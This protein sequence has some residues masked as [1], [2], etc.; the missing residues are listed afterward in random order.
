MSAGSVVVGGGPA[1]AAAAITLRSRGRPVL[2]LERDR[3]TQHKI[4]GEFLGG[5]ALRNL[6]ALGIDGTA[7]GA[8]PI[9]RMR[10]VRD[11]RSAEAPLP[12]SGM[13]LSRRT[14]DMAL[15][16]QAEAAGV[17]VERG[18]RV[19]SSDARGVVTADGGEV[20]GAAV[21]LAT[22]KHEL[23]GS[24]RVLPREPEDLVGF[25]MHFRLGATATAELAGAVELIL[26]ADAYA[27]LQR[28]ED[29]RANL[30]LLADRARFQAAGSTWHGLL[31]NLTRES[32]WLRQ[33]L[34]GGTEL[35]DRPLSIHRVPYGYLYPGTP[36]DG[37]FRLG[38]Q[39]GVIPSFTGEGMAIALQS[40]RFAGE[41]IAAGG[42]AGGYHR[43]MR[44]RVAR[45]I[46]LAAGLYRIGRSPAGQRA[47]LLVARRCP[48]LLRVAAR[49]TRIVEY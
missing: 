24:P 7:L 42:E 33:R 1:G 21:L 39:F 47:L 48:A 44:Q 22:G 4:C 17:A 46:A 11:A 40:G 13:G 35:F 36:E 45:P 19:R 25:K 9:A 10:V 41:W 34:D 14:L 6:A 12:F 3:E 30:C 29:G 28:V 31:D 5:V 15:L 43:R 18:V 49:A 2:L 37:M 38:D 32:P 20:G 26:F 23:R 16:A 8:H 27:G